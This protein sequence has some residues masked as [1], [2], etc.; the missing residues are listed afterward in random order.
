MM[1]KYAMVID[2]HRCTGCGGCIIAC[3]NENNLQQ[4]VAWSSKIART[5]GV[6]P[7]VSYNYTP[8]LCNHCENAPCV[9]VCPTEAMHKTEGGITMTD[10][11][12]C[13]GCRYCMAACPYGVIYYNQEEPHAFWRDETA[14]IPDGTSSANGVSQQVGGPVVPYGNP[15]TGIRPQGVVEKCTFC[16]HRLESGD[17]PYCVEACPANARIFGDLDDPNSE[18]NQLLGKY[19]A[20]RLREDMGTE[21]KI[22]YVRSFNVGSYDK[23]KGGVE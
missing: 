13:I 8:T 19:P 15:E 11:E 20:S 12:K 1:T 4:G 21:P 14:L 16:S 10:A 22:F 17:L 9:A 7:N 5:E 6:F 23:T 2:L 3:K 18:V